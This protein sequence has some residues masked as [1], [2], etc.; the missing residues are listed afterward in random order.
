MSDVKNLFAPLTG[1]DKDNAAEI[2][3]EGLRLLDYP[4]MQEAWDQFDLDDFRRETRESFSLMLYT[5]KNETHL[6]ISLF[7]GWYVEGI[8]GFAGLVR[9]EALAPVWQ[10]HGL[11]RDLET[12]LNKINRRLGASI[13]VEYRPEG[14]R[15]RLACV[16]FIPLTEIERQG[17]LERAFTAQ[18]GY[19]EKHIIRCTEGQLFTPEGQDFQEYIQGYPLSEDQRAELESRKLGAVTIGDDLEEN[20]CASLVL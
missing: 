17:S 9:E 15:S 12:L 2:M 1:T 18:T 19:A 8:K 10:A 7:E 20:S 11:D 13:Q 14:V 5:L 6:Q 4:Q 3:E 16:T